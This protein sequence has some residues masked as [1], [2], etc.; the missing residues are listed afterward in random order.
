M[1]YS[2]LR[3]ATPCHNKVVVYALLI[4]LSVI[5]VSSRVCAAASTTVGVV[6]PQL[7]LLEVNG[8]CF[9]QATLML[10]SSELGL[11]VPHAEFNRWRMSLPSNVQPVQYQGAVYYPLRQF[12][13]L[14][15]SIDRAT[16][17]MLVQVGPG[18]LA[19]SCI[20]LDKAE[21]N[22]PHKGT[23]G[24]FFNYDLLHQVHAGLS[25]SN[26]GT[27]ELAG[28]NSWGLLSTTLLARDQQQN[29]QKNAF[30]RLNTSLRH[31]DPS[32]LRT[33]TLG[34]TYSRVDAWG[35]GVL[36]GGIQWGT[37]FATRPDFTTFPLPEL[38]GEAVMSSTVEIYANERRE[39]VDQLKAGPFSITN[40]PVVTGANDL[41]LI[42]RDVL[43]REQVIEQPFYASQ[44]LLRAG[45][46]DYTYEVGA[47]RKNYSQESNE[48]GRS[49]AAA[50]HQLG[51]N[52]RLTGGVRVEV[53]KDQ[54]TAGFSGAWLA[55]PR[56]GV[57][58]AS[59][60]GSTAQTADGGLASIGAEYR[61]RRFSL[62]AQTTATTAGFRQLGVREGD[63]PARR[64]SR[65]NLGVRLP[66]RG[67]L[68][69][70]Y[71]DIDQREG[72]DSRILGASYSISVLRGVALSLHA[73]QELE[74]HDSFVGLSLS[75]SLGARGSASL[76]H[77][78]DK[79]SFSNRLQLQRNLPRGNGFGYNLSTEDGH[80]QARRDYAQLM[81][82]GDYGSY[83]AE[84]VR[85][86]D[87]TAYRLNAAGG[88]VWLG[89]NVFATRRIDDSFSIVKVGD[90]P[91]VTVYNENHPVA[92][93]NASGAALIP[94]LRSFEKNRISF[95]Q[96]DLPLD[97]RLERR[98]ATIVPGYRRGVLVDFAV[99]AARGALLTVHLANGEPLP[100]GAS[101]RHSGSSQRFPVARRG[102]VWVT[103]L[104]ANN[105]LL[106]QWG[107]HSC[108][109]EASLPSNP[110][111]MPRIGP[112]ICQEKPQ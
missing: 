67:S 96:S 11:L 12:S 64:I 91:R 32:K 54:Q 4:L 39:S 111:P 41:R 108:H 47:I 105:Q 81:A 92:T 84:V 70:N 46:H 66:G 76:S 44:Q 52:N 2:K 71:V 78:R 24:G 60:A 55:G 18:Q 110:G 61:A 42:V 3:S 8:E 95:E 109:F 103:D 72:T 49:F 107:E 1:V 29:Q 21:F 30:V 85:F 22:L 98:D 75:A 5:A 58:T 26:S 59:L 86:G 34:D 37:N 93:T 15:Y 40:I 10:D 99:G 38:H 56:F 106:A 53:L 102:E 65:A 101:I 88:V 14:R 82:Q 17:S 35:R 104:Q 16:Q 20:N 33:L 43:G 45:L 51:I 77:N 73:S 50:S 100:A 7:L 23:R 89:S 48:Y 74:N 13:D 68:G 28:F 57:L 97:A 25:D 62:G 87:D 9:A 27:F 63:L 80:A 6:T 112:L 31:D 19:S 90:Y 79:D 69:L 36:Y 83:R 94:D